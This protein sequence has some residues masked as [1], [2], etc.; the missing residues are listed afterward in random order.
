MQVSDLIK[1]LV[2]RLCSEGDR[3]EFFRMALQKLSQP[4]EVVS[5]K[6]LLRFARR[7]FQQQKKN[8]FISN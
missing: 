4:T 1:V 6:D 5:E 7:L 3:R 2:D 8:H